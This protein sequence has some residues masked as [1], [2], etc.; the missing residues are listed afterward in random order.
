MNSLPVAI[1][2]CICFYLLPRT[3]KNQR[4]FIWIIY[5]MIFAI[6][7]SLFIFKVIYRMSHPAIWDFTAFYLYGKVAAGG[8]NFYLPENFHI[9]Y[10]S[11]HFPVLLN[12]PNANYSEFVSESVNVGFPYPPPTILYFAPLGFLSYNS[13]LIFWSLF[14][15]IFALACIYLAYLLFLKEYKLNGLILVSVLFFIFSP[16]RST[17]FYSQTNFILLFLLL[18]MKKFSNSKIAGVFLALAIFTKPL[19]LIFSLYFIFRKKWNIILSF[20][21]SCN[22]CSSKIFRKCFLKSFC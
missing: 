17:I 14:M 11:I 7:I 15:F 3:K 6:A 20:I 12:I 10:N 16:V 18:L 9:V 5:S 13:A 4:I 2:A 21:L 19:M 8:Y 22:T 1:L